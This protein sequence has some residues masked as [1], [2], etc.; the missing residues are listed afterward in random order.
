MNE[1]PLVQNGIEAPEGPPGIVPAEPAAAGQD[2]DIAAGS[3]VDR[4]EDMRSLARR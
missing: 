4:R 2:V 3:G 1:Q